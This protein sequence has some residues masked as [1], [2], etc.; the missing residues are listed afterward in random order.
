[1]FCSNSN[2]CKNNT[3]HMIRGVKTINVKLI[4]GCRIRIEA[5]V[6]KCFFRIL[7]FKPYYGK[8]SIAV[9]VLFILCVVSVIIAV[10]VVVGQSNY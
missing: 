10:V 4:D 5:I 2:N 6:S 8:I 1:M 3:R 7:N 9:V